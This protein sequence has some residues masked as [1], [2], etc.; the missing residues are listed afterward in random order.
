MMGVAV[1]EDPTL[2]GKPCPERRPSLQSEEV[3]GGFAEICF[4]L[5]SFVR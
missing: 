2:G 5:S 4:C 3:A 1:L